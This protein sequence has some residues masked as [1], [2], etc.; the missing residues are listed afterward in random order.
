MINSSKKRLLSFFVCIS[1]ILCSLVLPT[2]ILAAEVEVPTTLLLYNR[3]FEDRTV[4]TNGFVGTT[5]AGNTIKLVTG[6]DGN[7]YMHWVADSTISPD[8]GHFNI[9]IS[10]YL[11]EEGSVVLRGKFRTTDASSSNRQLIGARAYDYHNGDSIIGEDGK[12]LGYYA[13]MDVVLYANRTYASGYKGALKVL[14]SSTAKRAD[15]FVDVAFVFTWTDKTDVTIKAYYD[16]STTPAATSSMSSKGYDAR[17]C[18][19]RFQVSGKSGL[20]WDMDDLQIYIANTTDAA[21]AL[22]PTFPSTNRGLLFN[23]SAG[24]YTDPDQYIGHYFFKV[25]VDNALDKDGT[26]VY[27][28]TEKPFS[29]KNG[30]IYFPLSSLEAVIGAL[31]TTA[32]AVTVDGVKCIKI[33]DI[34]TVLPGYYASVSSAGLVAISDE[35]NVFVDGA[36]DE[37]TIPVMQKFIFDHVDS[38]LEKVE[39]FGVT[40]GQYLDHPYLFAN[41]DKFD[42]LRETYLNADGSADPVLLGY[43]TNRVTSAASVYK[44]YALETNG[45]YSGL[46]AKKGLGG[47]Q[48]DLYE[49]PYLDDQGYDIGGR[50]SQ[51]TNHSNN[52]MQLAFAY[53]ITREDKYARLAYDYAV[54]IGGW[55]HWGPGHFLNCAD[56]AAPYSITYDWLYDAWVELGLDVDLITEII[57]THGVIPGY[58]S[59]QANTI[60]EGWMRCISGV[61]TKSGWGFNGTNNWNAVCSSGMVIASL[62]IA[63]VTTDSTGVYIDT[64]VNGTPFEK[65][66]LITALGDHTGMTTYQDY[67][68]WLINECYYG[69]AMKGL[70][71]YVPD[72]S[73]IESSGYWS[74]GTNN[75]FEMVAAMATATEYNTGVATDFGM[76]D[77]WGIDRTCYYALN[78]QSSD[79]HSF[80]YH[81]S[82]SGTVG[83]QDTS[84]FPFYGNYTGKTDLSEIRKIALASGKSG[85]PTIQDVLFYEK[86]TGDFEK[87]ALQY[88]WEGINGYVFRDSWESGAIYAGI[89][90]DTNNLGHGQIDSGSFVYHNGGTVWFCDIGTENYNCY[91]FWGGATR[92]RYYKMSAEGNNTLFLANRPAVPYG[93]TLNGFGKIIE[94]GDNDYGAYTVIDNTSVYG[95]YAS[96]AYRGMLLTNDRRTVVIQDEVEFLTAET[97]YWVGHT[98]QN[99]ILSVDGKT[100]YMTDGKTVIR[101]TINDM[102]DSGARFVIE[103]CYTFHLPACEGMDELAQEYYEAGTHEDNY[104]RSQFKKLTIALDGVTSVKLA[105]VIEEIAVGEISPIGYEW[106]SILDWD[107][108]TP[109]SDG[110]VTK[111]ETAYHDGENALVGNLTVSKGNLSV[112]TERVEGDRALVL[113][114]ASSTL[115]TSLTLTSHHSLAEYGFLADRTVAAEIDV[116]TLTSLPEGVRIA[117][118]GAGEKILGADLASLGNIAAGEWKRITLLVDGESNKYLVIFGDT[119]VSSGKF[120][121]ASVEDLAISVT[122]PEGAITSGSLV[123]DNMRLRVFGSDYTA[124][125]SVFSGES[126]ATWTDRTPLTDRL[127]VALATVY[128]PVDLT[129]GDTPIVDIGDKTSY[130]VTDGDGDTLKAVEIYRWTELADC[131]VKGATV[132]L[133]ASNTHA[134]V[135]VTA[136]ITVKTCGYDFRATALGLI[137]EVDGDT[138]HYRS[139]KVT[140]S[141]V[142]ASGETITE[143]YYSSIV[144]TYKGSLDT[145]VYEREIDGGYYY[146]VNSGWALSKGG[147]SL[148]ESD[149]IVTDANCTFYQA[150]REHKAAFV[151]V[152]GG[153]VT[154]Y[155]NVDDFKSK[156]STVCDRIC[157]LDDIIFDS[158][159]VSHKWASGA[160]LY[161]NGHTLTYR[162]T[163]SSDHMYQASSGLSIY[164]PGKLVGESTVANLFLATGG[165][166]LVDGVTIEAV[167]AI[168]DHRGGTITFVDCDVTVTTASSAFGVRNRNNANTVIPTV[169]L[170]GCTINMPKITGATPVLSVAQNAAIK[171]TDTTVKVTSGGVLVRLENTTVG[172]VN[173]FDYST[174]FDKMSFML[175]DVTH[176]CDTLASISTND[177]S[178]TTYPEMLEKIG[179][180]EG[181]SIEE[182]SD[183]LLLYDGCIVARRNGGETPYVVT[184][185]ENAA[186]VTF[187]V[188]SQSV[189]EYWVKGSVP[190]PDSPTVAALTASAPDGQKYCF[191]ADAI[192]GDVQL[193][194]QLVTDFN[195]KV[196]L[197]LHTAF[198]VNIFV[199]VTDGVSITEFT[200][201][202]ERYSGVRYT[203]DGKEYIKLSVFIENPAT[204]AESIL[205]GIRFNDSNTGA[206]N[207]YANTEISVVAYAERILSGEYSEEA[208]GLMGNVLKY[209]R[210][211][212]DYSECDADGYGAVSALLAEY[213]QYVTAAS[214][215]RKETSLE[216]LSPAINAA[217]LYLESKTCFR[218]YVTDGY[219]GEITLSYVSYDGTVVTARI[220]ASESLLTEVREDGSSVRYIDLSMKAYDFASPVT[221]SAVIDGNTVSGEYSLAMYY[222]SAATDLGIT[223]D[224]LN[225]ICAY[226]ESARL[227][228]DFVG[229]G[230][231]YV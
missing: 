30:Q 200:V 171:L 108:S 113:S 213:E 5:F 66:Q 123:L 230:E 153:V 54:A 65:S 137:A 1:I 120:V 112:S 147:A 127:S 148:D 83:A 20:S 15:E 101:V 131:L 195:I 162:T 39:A 25:N 130:E 45:S 107:E 163:V 53:Q 14:K 142:L 182:P 9:D 144:A 173:N 86:S 98:Q 119:P 161:L 42:S 38:S 215:D 226:A 80:N 149:M 141:W 188:G 44:S 63:G 210:S 209:I 159:D 193:T 208:K 40:S 160:K 73:Y 168:T 82:G 17:P 10:T 121:D 204:A 3:D 2:G 231:N 92:Y 155:E 189:G 179:Y 164:G 216:A 110:S 228:R 32:P 33:E 74:Y 8:H 190:T 111:T 138:I 126:I 223:L 177:P 27:T 95:G 78:T 47:N 23:P 72:G 68:V 87:P 222:H 96:S 37:A 46:N 77:A 105:I 69:M 4:I 187:T 99:T 224:F 29:D 6:D 58:Y 7:T 52:M 128:L 180:T 102:N 50:H 16:G 219:E 88:W 93:Q 13:G 31:A 18:Y 135:T 170:D 198:T 106:Q 67:A 207:V 217:A 181:A 145:T 56:A 196:N 178:G 214:V 51:A 118:M 28:L 192:E 212:Y 70:N 185:P 221:V 21:S 117:L 91:G 132:E 183:D 211:A 89:M 36:D 176:N 156:I 169:V 124:L 158:S 11:P 172:T 229:S 122:T 55:E 114:A 79:Y 115:P 59:R 139:G 116:S 26:T 174:A 94:T 151:T 143:D 48:S 218:F 129:V 191:S 136:P 220:L 125:D 227:Y 154:S 146:Y 19:F 184:K 97:A 90:G 35:K 225:A 64:V 84:W 61:L 75:F 41:Q 199:Q 49:M 109:S 134:P 165:S 202:G 157:L 34:P 76:L 167:R 57:F 206:R 194:A 197:S 43:I 205:L 175:G 12:E 201:N 104:D 103:D 100:A 85:A 140:V 22:A 152:R 133:H 71:Q 60:P 186:L 203:I 24:A 166:V 62:A 150:E 81:D